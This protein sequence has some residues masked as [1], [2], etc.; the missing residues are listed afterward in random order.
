MKKYLVK[1]CFDCNDGDDVF[2]LQ[3]I[4]ENTKEIIDRNLTKEV[5]FGSCNFGENSC[6]LQDCID[7][8]EITEMQFKVFEELNLL[9]FG[10]GD[11]YWIKYLDSAAEYAYDDEDLDEE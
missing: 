2:G 9:N 5:R 3:V 4:D 10:E 8:E 6:A 1:I 7:V 11:N